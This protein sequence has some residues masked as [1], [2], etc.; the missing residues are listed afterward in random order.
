MLAGL[1]RRHLLKQV[2]ASDE[3]HAGEKGYHPYT[4]TVVARIRIS[5]VEADI[6]RLVFDS[7]SLRGYASE[8]DNGEQLQTK[9]E[10]GELPG[11]VYNDNHHYRGIEQ[12]IVHICINPLL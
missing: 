8:Y 3:T 11:R 6:F 1:H 10:V 4:N 9:R 12:S 5:V 2:L 7:P